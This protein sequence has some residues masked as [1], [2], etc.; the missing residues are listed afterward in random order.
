MRSKAWLTIAP[1]SIRT[2]IL[3]TTITS[4]TVRHH[5]FRTWLATNRKDTR[6]MSSVTTFALTGVITVHRY[7]VVVLTWPACI[8]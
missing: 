5:Q 7:L 6:L 3:G 1:V 4:I 2:P 8:T